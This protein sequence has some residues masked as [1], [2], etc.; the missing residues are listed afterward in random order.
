MKSLNTGSVGEIHAIVDRS[1][2]IG[3]QD[4]NGVNEIT[5]C[6]RKD[7]LRLLF[8]NLHG[9]TPVT[10]TFEGRL[11]TGGIF[12]AQ[13]DVLIMAGG[14]K[15]AALVSPNP[16]NPEAILTFRTTEPGPVRVRLFDLNGRM[17]RSLLDESNAPAGYHDVRI[18]GRDEHGGRLASGLYFFRIDAHEGEVVGKVSVLK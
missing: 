1:V 15:L 2:V 14:G 16:L 12:R 11:F 9:N 5:A 17:I 4:A 8:S 3:D 18:D 7:D 10:V 13:M 6:F